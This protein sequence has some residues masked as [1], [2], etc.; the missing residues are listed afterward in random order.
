MYLF[1]LFAIII[2]Y[3]RSTNHRV[4]VYPISLRRPLPM[5]TLKAPKAQRA[6]LLRVDGCWLWGAQANKLSLC[7]SYVSMHKRIKI[8][9][10]LEAGIGSIIS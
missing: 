2:P 4:L 10:L 3:E 9:E 1:L 8:Q 6:G 5:P 7:S